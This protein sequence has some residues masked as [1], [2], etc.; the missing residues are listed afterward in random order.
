MK[1]KSKIK[2]KNVILRSDTFFAL[3]DLSLMTYPLPP[4]LGADGRIVEGIMT[5][6]CPDGS[7]NISPMGPIVDKQFWQFVLRP[8]Q[9]STT[10]QNLKRT[11]QAVFHVTDDIGL[12]AQAALGSPEPLPAT[13]RATAIEGA[14]LTD[15]CRWYALQVSQLDDSQERTCIVATCLDQ[16]RQR[17]FLGYNRAQHAVLEAAILATRVELLPA[18]DVLTELDRLKLPV[19]KTASQIEQHAFDFLCLQIESKI[20]AA[21]N[22]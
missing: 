3:V 13:R 7:I 12:F 17:D 2:I 22:S 1:S 18:E 10:Y 21:R 9:T 5:T 11:G 15:A 6:L 19:S 4:Q 8:Y 20:A 16:G 14:I